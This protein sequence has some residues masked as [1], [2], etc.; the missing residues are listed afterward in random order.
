MTRALITGGAGF[1]GSHLCERLIAE[2]HE[3]ICVDNL[4]TG[5]RENVAHLLGRGDFQFLCH[6]VSRPFEIDGPV[7]YVLHFAS[8][9]SP[10]RSAPP[11]AAA[12]RSS[13]SRCRSTIRRPGSP[14]SPRPARGSAGSPG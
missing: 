7:D 14:T 10:R 5:R 2:G 12:A 4:V 11:W 9:A 3:V 1:L 8:P 13:S 6:D